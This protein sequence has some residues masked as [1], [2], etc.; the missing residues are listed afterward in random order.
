MEHIWDVLVIGGGQSGLACAYYLRRAGLDYQVLDAQATCGGAW[1]QTWDALTLFSTA[2]HSSLPG[3]MMPRTSHTFPLRAEVIDYLCQYEGRYKF[4]IERSV[5]VTQ[6]ERA[7]DG[8]FHL[9]TSQGQR[10][11]RAVISA[12][13]TWSKPFIPAVPGMA[14]FRG[15]QIHSSAYRNAEPFVGKRVLVVGEGNS[16]AQIL[17]EVSQVASVKWAVRKAPQFLPDDVDGRVLFDI[18]SA[19]YHAERSGKPFDPS[20]YSLGN[21]VMVP[22][23][24]EA[25]ARGVLDQFG[26][27]AEIHAQGVVWEDGS[28]EDFDAIIWCTGFGYATDHLRSLVQLDARGKTATAGSKSLEVEGLWLL[29]Y[30]GWTGYA[31]ATLVGAGRAAKQAIDEIQA[32]LN[33]QT[34]SPEEKPK[35]L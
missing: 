3:W 7:P 16:G 22:S 26:S 24:V 4:P 6:V 18:G 34:A 31:S 23:V 20:S 28:Q 35:Q 10:K 30:G 32:Y 13:G 1:L 15:I 29:G 25:R 27:L 17:A 5:A 19:K 12:T 14:S 33:P 2:Q 21:I 8:I 11:A 9:T